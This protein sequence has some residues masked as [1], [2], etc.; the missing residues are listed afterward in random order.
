MRSMSPNSQTFRGLVDVDIA[1]VRKVL[2]KAAQKW[3]RTGG[4]L[5]RKRTVASSPAAMF[6]REPKFRLLEQGVFEKARKR[7]IQGVLASFSQDSSPCP[8]G[9]SWQVGGSVE[10]PLIWVIARPN[11]FF[12]LSRES[13]GV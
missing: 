1:A 7:A 11:R 8:I 2:R 12:E 3:E 9:E 5:E 6:A 4:H 13:P 10:N